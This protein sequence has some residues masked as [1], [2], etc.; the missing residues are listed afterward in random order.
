[1]RDF[2]FH[3]SLSEEDTGPGERV[4]RSDSSTE[5]F[6]TFFKPGKVSV[7]TDLPSGFL[8]ADRSGNRDFDRVPHAFA[9]RTTDGRLDFVLVAVRLSAG[10]GPL[11]AGRRKHE[12]HRVADWVARQAGGEEDFLIVGNMGFEAADELVSAVPLQ[13]RALNSDGRNT[14]VDVDN[15]RPEANVLYRPVAMGEVDQRFGLAIISPSAALRTGSPPYDLRE[16]REL[17]TPNRPVVFRLNIPW[18]DDD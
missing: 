15:P 1:M 6:V 3:H 8:A 9:F 12:L 2:G 7:A 5:W 4:Q 18:R 13:F 16:M 14:R 10:P 11:R 17:L